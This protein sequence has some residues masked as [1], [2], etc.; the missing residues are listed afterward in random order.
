[1]LFPGV[2]TIPQAIELT[3]RFATVRTAEP[4]LRALVHRVDEPYWTDLLE[5]LRRVDDATAAPRLEALAETLPEAPKGKRLSRSPSALRALAKRLR[6][7]RPERSSFELRPGAGTDGGPL[8]L[9]PREVADA[10]GGTSPDGSGTT[11]PSSAY[12]RACAASDAGQGN[13]VVAGTCALVLRAE[14]VEVASLADGRWVLVALGTALQVEE[15]LSVPQAWESTGL[16]L[17]FGESG[18]LL[19]DAAQSVESA[20]TVEGASVELAM[21]PGRYDVSALSDGQCEAWLLAPSV[22]RRVRSSARRTA[23]R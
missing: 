3:Y 13:V 18:A 11:E 20:R 1:V 5:H 14:A 9:L 23:K 10:W 17:E 16:A 6:R 15:A 12:D 4:L 2:V 8:V 21:A 22:K 19:L 7:V